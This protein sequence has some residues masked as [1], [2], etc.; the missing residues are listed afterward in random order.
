[1]AL[2]NLPEPVIT[3]FAP[4]PTGR[5]HAGNI[6]SY[7]SAWLLTK[8]VGGTVLLRIEDLDSSRSRAA[9]ADH[10]KQDFEMLGLL[11]DG[12]VMYQSKRWEAY[13]AAFRAL[14]ERGLTYP[15]F[16]TRA[17][18]HAASAPHAGEQLVYPGTCALLSPEEQSTRLRELQHDGRQPS[19]R[20]KVGNETI[21]FED[22]LQ[23]QQHFSCADDCGDFV[24]RRSDGGFAYQLAVVVDDAA[25][26]VNLVVRGAD[27]LSSTPL[28]IY[29]QQLLDLEQVHYAHVP[30]ICAADGRRI[31]K[32]DHDASLEE[33]LVQY[34]T[35]EGVLGHIAFIAGLINKDQA[36]TAQELLESAQLSAIKGVKKI[37]WH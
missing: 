9:Y 1:M 25:Q 24:I 34:K 26:G 28:Q 3:R 31:A 23:G 18:I 19:I 30:L 37:T 6:F 16:C 8:R 32:R 29:L 22:L 13:E 36:L 20:L 5:M 10:I 27:L 2:E 4:S 14:E 21:C 15:C 17:D 7:L 35:P 12:E 33:L 11:W